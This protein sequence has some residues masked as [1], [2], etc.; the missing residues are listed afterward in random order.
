MSHL[1]AVIEVE[2]DKPLSEVRSKAELL[3]AKISAAEA[4][5][6]SAQTAGR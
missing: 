4:S 5:L 2:K 6:A 3:R 1:E